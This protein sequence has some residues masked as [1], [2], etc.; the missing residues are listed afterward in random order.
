MMGEERRKIS[1]HREGEGLARCGHTCS[2]H[3][4][5]FSYFSLRF[6]LRSLVLGKRLS[7][8]S[9]IRLSTS[10]SSF[11]V[12]GFIDVSMEELSHPASKSHGHM[13]C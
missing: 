8:R 3:F 7:G 13:R 5:T 6:F 12:S 1:G 9:I 11:Q 10:L 4:P 2:P